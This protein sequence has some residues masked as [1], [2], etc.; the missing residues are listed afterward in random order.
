M[1]KF[2]FFQYPIRNK[3]WPEINLMVAKL[4]HT[5]TIWLNIFQLWNHTPTGTKLW[6]PAGYL[7]GHAS[8]GFLPP[9]SLRSVWENR[10]GRDEHRACHWIKTHKSYST[11]NYVF[12]PRI[13]SKWKRKNNVLIHIHVSLNSN[14]R[15][16]YFKMNSD[17]WRI[18]WI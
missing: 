6:F 13:V 4:K 11:F 7:L 5:T 18:L 10:P 9:V 16:K 15:Q 12:W 14:Q 8:C 3:N 17:K 1:K 2:Y